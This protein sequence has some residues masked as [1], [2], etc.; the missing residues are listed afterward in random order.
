MSQP[1]QRPGVRAEHARLRHGVERPTGSDGVVRAAAPERLQDGAVGHEVGE[2]DGL[3]LLTGFPAFLARRMCAK[4]LAHEER[5]L[6]LVR[7]SFVGQ[8]RQFVQ[9]LPL[10]EARKRVEILVGDTLDMDLGL[11]GP[12]VARLL[13]EVS[14]IHN[15]AAVYYPAV[16]AEQAQ[17]V[18]V[19][20]TRE[21]LSVALRMRRLERFNHY[22]T[23]FVAGDRTGVILEE[24][25]DA[26][27]RFRNV[28]ERTKCEAERLVRAAQRDLPIS[29][30]RPAMVVGDS[31]TGESDR[32][33][34]SHQLLNLIVNAPLNVSLPLP[35]EGA[36]P[37]NLVPV[38]YVVDA[39]HAI[40]RMP[41]GVGLTFHL[42][43][44]NPFSAKHVYD[45]VADRAERKRPHASQ[46]ARI[47]RTVLRW[48]LGA[49]AT[50]PLDDF[51]EQ[52]SR[53]VVFN[54]RN[55]LALLHDS[56]VRCPSFDRYVGPLVAQL[57]RAK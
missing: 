21:M 28:I 35:A 36:F 50:S 12:E 48:P 25:L 10:P 40:S 7:E 55:T 46:A 5:V 42:T 47:V 56:P 44:P 11:S 17:R 52:A 33:L 20:G 31:R 23:A 18:N 54:C 16:S 32:Q 6:L 19:E 27:Q 30:Y 8:A 41:A 14:V 49:R 9:R 2:P 29:I 51:L 4:L 34:G 1:A 43:D 26:G 57:R 37:L 53:L 45:L 15:M 39:A 38:D 3:V 13:S 22:S 24:E